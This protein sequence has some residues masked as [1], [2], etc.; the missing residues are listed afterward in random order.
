MFTYKHQAGLSLLELM[1]AMVII[2]VLV[3]GITEMYIDNRQSYMFQQGQSENQENNR[4]ALLFLHQELTKAGYRRE[5]DKAA[6]L[7]FKA[8]G[9]TGGCPAFGESFAA[10]WDTNNRYLCIRYQP[11]DDKDRDC[12]G[13]LPKTAATI[14]DKPYIDGG[15]VIFERF[16]I[17][18]ETESLSCQATHTVNGNI[19]SPN[20]TGE[21]ITGIVDLRFEF[22]VGDSTDSRTIKE[23]KQ[24]NS[25]ISEPILAVRYTL[26]TRSTN[27]NITDENKALEKWKIAVGA[28]D[29]EVEALEDDDTTRQL[30][31]FSQSTITLRNLMP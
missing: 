31:H 7:V 21:L 13:N 2:S 20:P 30:Y 12:L 28:T 16:F 23:Y 15:E 8:S 27:Q 3:L 18:E 1:V 17:D 10:I 9:S 14:K 29:E 22:G 11:H 25:S 4:F 19:I 6:E 5:P 24:D 26:L